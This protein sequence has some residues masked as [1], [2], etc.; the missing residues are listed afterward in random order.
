[1]G[2]ELKIK[3]SMITLD[4]AEPLE[5]A[6]F[7]AA[8]L[9]WVIPF[10]DAE[11][12]AVAPPDTEQGAYPGILIQ[13]NPDYTPPLWPEEPGA[14]QQMAHIDF[15]VNDVDGAVRHAISCGATV[16]E[17]QFSDGWRVMLD[18]AGHPF[19]LCNMKD[20]FASPHFALL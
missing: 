15:V 18:P 7:Y 3:L 11:Y 12:V 17:K 19:C 13:R 9:K 4:C 1:M 16:A 6:K 8:L 5:L 10:E 2:D 20:L 14:Q